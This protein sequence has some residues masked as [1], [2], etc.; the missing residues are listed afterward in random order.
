MGVLKAKGRHF[1]RGCLVECFL[2]G[3]PVEAET[4]SDLGIDPYECG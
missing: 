3:R 4:I 1:R 2:E